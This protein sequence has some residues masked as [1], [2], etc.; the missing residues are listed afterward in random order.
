MKKQNFEPKTKSHCVS[1]T[2]INNFKD[3]VY[4]VVLEDGPT[5]SYGSRSTLKYIAP[6]SINAFYEV[7]PELARYYKITIRIVENPNNLPF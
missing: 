6:D 2:N 5:S 3:P 7:L 1:K 4:C